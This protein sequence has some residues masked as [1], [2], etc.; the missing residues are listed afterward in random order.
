MVVMAIVGLLVATSVPALSRYAG[1]VRLKAATREVVGLLSLA[2]SLAIG[3]RQ[4]RTVV[5]DAAQRRLFIQET[6]HTEPRTIRLAS[7]LTVEATAHGEPIQSLVFKPTGALE[8][9][10]AVTIILSNGPRRHTVTVA[11]TTG[12]ISVE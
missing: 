10:G 5:I 1:Q 12:S 4:P 8:A 11:S 2:R 9:T 7:S 6:A 3:S